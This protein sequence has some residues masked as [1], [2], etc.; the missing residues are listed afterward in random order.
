MPNQ[1]H[2]QGDSFGPY[3][4]AADHETLRAIQDYLRSEDAV[5]RMEAASDVN[6]PAAEAVSAQLLQRFG[7]AVENDRVKQF[8]GWTIRKVMES[9]GFALAQ[10]N[11][12]ICS[13]GNIFTR[14]S[15][16]RRI[17]PTLTAT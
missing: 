3:N 14:A 16:Y 6:K 1:S 9:K 4:G 2:P 12:K 8:V 10:Q 11:C 17:T 5:A 15:R 7:K 13:K